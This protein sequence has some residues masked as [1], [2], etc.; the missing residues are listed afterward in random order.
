M[1]ALTQKQAMTEYYIVREGKYGERHQLTGSW[2][3][4][5]PEGAIA[6][7]LTESGAEDDDSWKAFPVTN[8]GDVVR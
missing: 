2:Q 7:M 8:Q 5:S 6:Q 3:A 4:A 1:I